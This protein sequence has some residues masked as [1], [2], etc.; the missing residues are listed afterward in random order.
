MASACALAGASDEQRASSERRSNGAARARARWR[1]QNKQMTATRVATAH[2]RIVHRW[3]RDVD[4]GAQRWRVVAQRRVYWLH[5]AARIVH[6]DGGRA[7]LVSERPSTNAH[8]EASRPTNPRSQCS[9]AV[10]PRRAAR[11][12]ERP[13]APMYLTLGLAGDHR[14]SSPRSQSSPSAR[15]SERE[16]CAPCGPPTTIL[17]QQLAGLTVHTVTRAA[18]RAGAAASALGT[19]PPNRHAPTINEFRLHRRRSHCAGGDQI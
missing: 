10:E 1:L 2:E 12:G 9:P 17:L 16:F 6:A 14:H 15:N 13:R 3:P 8:C 11:A 18:Q 19:P 7:P 5:A 4:S